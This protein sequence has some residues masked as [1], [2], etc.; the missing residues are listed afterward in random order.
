MRTGPHVHDVR[1]RQRWCSRV[2]CSHSR[3]AVDCN[4]RR[5]A[6]PTASG[7]VSGSTPAEPVRAAQGAL[8]ALNR[9]R[10]DF[11]VEIIELDWHDGERN[12]LV[13]AQAVS[14]RVQAGIGRPAGGVFARAGWFALRL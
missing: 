13:P 3:A 7:S 9:E 1:V 2:S 6:R 4:A 14:C 5:A 10:A 8:L 11:A 12:R